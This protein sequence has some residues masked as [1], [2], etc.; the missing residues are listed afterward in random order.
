M[1]TRAMFPPAALAAALLIPVPAAP[2]FAAF[3]LIRTYDGPVAGGEFGR[4]CLVVGDMDGDGIDDFAIGAPGDATGGANAGRVFIYSGGDP[5]PASPAWVIT[6]TPGERLGHGL[7]WAYVDGDF[8]PD[9]VIGAP[10]SGAMTGRIVVAY[11]GNPLGARATASVSGTTAGG[12]FGWALDGIHFGF[13]TVRVIVGAPEANAGAGEVHGLAAGVP[14][15][16]AF[17]LHGEEAGERFGFALSDAGITRGF[18][19]GPEFLVGAP[20]ATPNG[21]GSG[22][23]ALFLY[24]AANDTLADQVVLGA[25]GSRLGESISGG[26]D[27]NPNYFEPS[28]D[29][30]VGAPGSDPGGLS[31]AGSSFVYAD[32][33]PFA[34]D[35]AASQAAFGST[36]RLM[37][38]VTG[39]WLPD[40]AVGE[41]NAVRVYPGPLYPWT[42]PVA[43]IAG[44]AAGDEFGLAIASGGHLDPAFTARVQLLIG[45]PGHA[46]AGRVYI[47]TDLS[48]PTGVPPGNPARIALAAPRPNPSRGAF[49]LSVDLPRATR[50]RLTVLDVAGRRVATLHDGPLGPGRIPFTWSPRGTDA[51]GLYWGVLEADGE[52]IT[53]RMARVP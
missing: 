31:G 30:V 38:D 37:R 9:L 15:T 22:R 1:L 24:D 2:A 36:V 52:R 5:L 18:I 13:N 16:R 39:T 49:S 23:A 4:S 35:G 26:V 25:A 45:A 51:A 7:G 44:E 41:S 50:A 40:L 34:Y 3:T 29:M 28:D 43:S 19:A 12:R 32:Q 33:A 17:V 48:A 11:G 46:G 53:R 21:P 6:G 20:D 14:P 10:G 27:I 42:T 8:V 47:Y